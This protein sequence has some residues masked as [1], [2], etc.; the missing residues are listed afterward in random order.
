MEDPNAL[1]PV[2]AAGKF[3]EISAERS[4]FPNVALEATRHLQIEHLGEFGRALLK[5]P[6]LRACFSELER[7]V[8]TQTSALAIEVKPRA[9]GAIWFGHKR[10]VRPTPG[11]WQMTLYVLA[12][13]LKVA[14]LAN[15]AWSP[16]EISVTSSS[17]PTRARA[18][19]AL[20]ASPRFGQDRTGFVVPSAMLALPVAKSAGAEPKDSADDLWNTA[21]PIRYAD[22]IRRLIRLYARDGW[23]TIE[24]A[25]E[26]SDASP[27]TIQRR[28]KDEQTTF[29]RLV[30]DT[31][32]E[33]ASELLQE[34][35]ATMSDIARELGYHHQGDFTRAFRRW[36][37]VT[38][39]EYRR[40]RQHADVRRPL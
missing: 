20:G 3:R 10:L 33:M 35:D 22:A 26:V 34:T 21:P 37:G 38:P 14:Q 11:E 25:G 40:A 4:G 31:R 2:A 16:D 24:R 1:V 18:V 5:A 28:L 13:M 9:D 36:A 17:S 15:E 19:E 6:T 29:S 32:S 30:E 12:V 7:L 27:R 39:S 8:G 23:L